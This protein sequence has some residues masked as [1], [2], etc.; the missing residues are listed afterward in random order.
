[1][2]TI[3]I[4]LRRDG[5]TLVCTQEYRFTM[6]AEAVKWQGDREAFRSADGLLPDFK[7]LSL[8]WLE[9]GVAHQAGRRGATHEIEDLGGEARMWAD[10]VIMEETRR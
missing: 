8:E 9:K 3:R 7:W 5:N 2:K 10:N 1:M 6:S 4:T